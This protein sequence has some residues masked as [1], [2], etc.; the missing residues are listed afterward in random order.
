M[1]EVLSH[2]LDC[3]RSN[4]VT[5]T[6]NEISSGV[7]AVLQIVLPS[8]DNRESNGNSSRGHWDVI[9]DGDRVMKECWVL[10]LNGDGSRVPIVGRPGNRRGTPR[11]E[12]VGCRESDSRN[13]RKEEENETGHKS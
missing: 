13:Q 10:E 1:H 5:I 11:R 6:V 8:L 9:R 3:N 12:I 4:R 2:L 7:A